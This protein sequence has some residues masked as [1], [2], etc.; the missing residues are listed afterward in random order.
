M[1]FFSEL[2]ERR[3]FQIVGI[4]LGAM[5]VAFEFTDMIVE[6]Y[7]LTADLVDMILIGSLSMLPTIIMIAWFHGRPGRDQWHRMEKIGI[8][9]NVLVTASLLVFSINSQQATAGPEP[10]SDTYSEV[11]TL[12]DASGQPVAE[13]EVPRAQ[14]INRVLVTFLSPDTLPEEQRWMGYGLPYLISEGI[15]RDEYTNSAT[16]FNNYAQGMIWQMKRAGNLDGLNVSNL[17]L[18]EV[19]ERYGYDFYLSGMLTSNQQGQLTARVSLY[20]TRSNAVL[21]EAE[22]SA[23]GM[24]E[25]ANRISTELLASLPS[26]RANPDVIQAN[27]DIRDVLTNRMDALEAF[28]AGKI[29]LLLENDVDQAM[30]L[31]HQAI[32]MDREFA[33][34]YFE[35]ADV[36]SDMGQFDAAREPMK[37]AM[38]LNHKF[39]TADRYQLQ[40]MSYRLRGRFA[41]AVAVYNSWIQNEPENYDARVSYAQAL[42]WSGGDPEEIISHFEKALELNPAADWIYFELA[43]LHEVLDQFDESIALL[44]RYFEER[45]NEYLALISIGDILVQQ[46]RLAEAKDYYERG[47]TL[48]AKMV[49]PLKKLTEH[50]FRTGDLEQTALYLDDVDFTA[51]APRQQATYH[52]LSAA[53]LK[54]QGNKRDALKAYQMAWEIERPLSPFDILIEQLGSLQLFLDAGERETA[55]ALI[56]QARTEFKPPMD[57]LI[58]VGVMIMHLMDG[59]LE[60]AEQSRQAVFD[61][62]E[63]LQRIDLTYK[64]AMMSGLIL[65]AG[66]HHEQAIAEFE[67]AFAIFDQ[68]IHGPDRSL[69]SE[70][71]F[72]LVELQHAYLNAGD[73]E[74]V[75]RTGETILGTWPYHPVANLMLATAHA[76]EG[77][78]DDASDALERFDRMWGATE[79][80]ARVDPLLDELRAQLNRSA[81]QPAP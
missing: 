67:N 23:G 16:P 57:G 76:R 70:H 52:R 28:V 77:R 79:A 39:V 47:G 22:F 75:I 66:G 48:D 33:Q 29:R 46:G 42:K 26:A 62:L 12:T 81:P 80:D 53:M 51:A 7:Q 34:A 5:F 3:V 55:E 54:A 59:E 64:T 74:G 24:F 10:V 65:A 45:P 36:M 38:A 27:I 13:V 14:F 11:R 61:T 4:Y 71:Y 37:M 73:L 56:A 41:K 44:T 31:W 60:L 68:T 40:A 8:P 50:A 63:F 21:L 43:T 58:N 15:R 35:I 32:E 17:L 78:L 6:R 72:I 18:K 9:L 25:L 69:N 19:S 30:S 49:T 2:L 1:S 20:E